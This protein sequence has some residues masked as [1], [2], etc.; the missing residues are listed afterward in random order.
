MPPVDL[1]H[2]FTAP[3]LFLTTIGTVIIGSVA[4]VYSLI[5]VGGR[6]LDRPKLRDPLARDPALLRARIR[7]RL[8]TAVAASFLVIVLAALDIYLTL[9]S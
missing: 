6:M 4:I 5:F 9:S 7:G 8:G 3:F 2:A 1:A